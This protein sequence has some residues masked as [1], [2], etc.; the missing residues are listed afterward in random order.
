MFV[1]SFLNRCLYPF[2]DCAVQTLSDRI[3]SA[4]EKHTFLYAG[5]G[6]L[7]FTLFYRMAV[8]SYTEAYIG[9]S[10]GQCWLIIA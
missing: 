7:Y 1:R 3:A 4:N 8:S 2:I 10:L 5:Q 9:S 6:V